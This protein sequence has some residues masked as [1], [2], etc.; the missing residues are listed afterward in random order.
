MIGRQISH[1]YIIR[2]LGGG[3][4]GVVYEAQDTRLPRSV[5]LKLLNAAVA[6]NAAALRRFTR[7]ARLMSS[8]NHPNICGVL[9]ADH[10]DGHAFIAME[11]LHGVSLKSRLSMERL[12]F[13]EILDIAVQISEGLAAAHDQGIIHRDVS[14]GNVFVT[15]SGLVKL[16][17]FGL[18]T[19][20]T[21]MDGD[22]KVSDEFRVAGTVAG[23]LHYMAPELLS[24]DAPPDHRCDLY[25]LGA[26]LYHMATGAPP[27]GTPPFGAP[28]HRTATQNALVMAIRHTPHVPVRTAAPE[29]P[30]ALGDLIDRLLAKRPADRFQT[31]RA[32]RS[33]LEVVRLSVRLSVLKSQGNATAP[34]ATSA[35]PP[36]RAIGIAVLPFQVIAS[37]DSMS[38]NLRDGLVECISSEL[39]C[40]TGVHVAP[41]TSTRALAGETARDI[42]A[43]L[44]VALVLEG[45]LQYDAGRVRVTA[46]LVEASRERSVHSPLVVER[47]GTDTFRV[48]DEI[49]REIRDG[50]TAALVSVMS[51]GRG[52]RGSR[53]LVNEGGGV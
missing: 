46:N 19:L 24:G 33:E 9:D 25:S 22:A 40:I 13:D 35:V 52:P 17:D 11:L 27:F 15:S 28:P 23:T 10:G 31:A 14:P 42:G 41:R 47:T 53:L 50:L 21:T 43:R 34:E 45:T 44:G 32:V 6:T 29:F 39:S 36:A 30:A 18:A 37:Q 16:L 49:A 12:A 4:T 2:A 26:L 20:V 8:L 48:Q 51:A 3:G 38:Q 1:F 5:A 7:E